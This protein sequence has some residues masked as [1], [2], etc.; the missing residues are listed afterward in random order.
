MKETIEGEANE[1]TFDDWINSKKDFFE[2]LVKE[3]GKDQCQ[4][5]TKLIEDELYQCP[6]KFII[7]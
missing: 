1:I 7:V 3:W 4:D 6:N 5:K 2:S